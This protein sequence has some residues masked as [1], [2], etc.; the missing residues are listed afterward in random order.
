V[1]K[2]FRLSASELDIKNKSCGKSEC[3]CERPAGRYRV[4]DPPKLTPSADRLLGFEM[5]ATLLARADEVIE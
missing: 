1:G 4:R 3:P 5:P 2:D